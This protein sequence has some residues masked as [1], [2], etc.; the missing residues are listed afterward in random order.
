[1]R[2]CMCSRLR[3][4][5]FGA[6]AG[7]MKSMAPSNLQNGACGF[8]EWVSMLR[9]ASEICMQNAVKAHINNFHCC[10]YLGLKKE[11]KK[12]LENQGLKLLTCWFISSNDQWVQQNV[13]HLKLLLYRWMELH[14]VK[15]HNDLCKLITEGPPLCPQHTGPQ[16]DF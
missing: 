2:R 8:S 1:M 9:W 6:F 3:L 5:R 14:G 16:S 12:I 15:V 11:K 7:L 10:H 13:G 4:S